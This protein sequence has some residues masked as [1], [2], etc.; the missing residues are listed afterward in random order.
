MP[1]PAQTLANLLL[2]GIGAAETGLEQASALTDRL[3]RRGEAALQRGGV[4]NE[5]LHRAPGAE[6]PSPRAEAEEAADEKADDSWLRALSDAQLAFLADAVA[7]ERA[8]R[9]AKES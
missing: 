1:D 8:R 5:P 9:G 4:P 7:R 3:I 2:A 6:T